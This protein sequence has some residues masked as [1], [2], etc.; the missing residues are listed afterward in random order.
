M[1]LGTDTM[2]IQKKENCKNR[3]VN[4]NQAGDSLFFNPSQTQ[5]RNRT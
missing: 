1:K 2:I 3:K 4:Q 5:L